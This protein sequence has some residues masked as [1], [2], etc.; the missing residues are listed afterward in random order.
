MRKVLPVTFCFLVLSV[1]SSG[2]TAQVTLTKFP[3][4][5]QLY[6]RDLNTNKAVVDITG[7]V[8]AS[9][10][11][12]QI[13]LKKYRDGNLQSTTNYTLFYLGPT[14]TFSFSPEITA[15]LHTYKFV[16]YGYK[17][18]KETQIATVNNVVAGD[19]YIIQGQSNAT[20]N[21]RGTYS[22]ANNADDP[23]NAPNRNWVRVYGNGSATS[24]YTHGWF[25]GKGNSYYD[26]DGQCGQWGMR[27]ASNLAGSKNIPIA[28]FNGSAPGQ[29]MWFFQRNDGNHTDA[30]T[31]YGRLLARI[32]EAGLANSIRGIIWFQGESDIV[33]SLSSSALT[34]DQ[35][36]TAFNNLK[37]DWKEDYPGLTNYY[38]FQ[39]RFGCG[40]STADNCLK[41]QEAQRQLDLDAADVQTLSVSNTNQLFDGGTINYCH[42][43]FYD[44]YKNMGD[45]VSKLMR[46]DLYNENSLPATINSPEPESTTFSGFLPTGEPN[47]ISITLKDQSTTFSQ[48]GDCSGL[49]RLDGGSFTVTSTA[50]SGRNILVSFSRNAGTTTNPTH[51]SYRSHDNVAAPVIVNSA[52]LALIHFDRLALPETATPP[53]PPPACTDI[54]EPNNA[55]TQY[56]GITG[57]KTYTANIGSAT[58]EDWFRFRTW[59]PWHYIRISIW[60]LT[61]NYDIYLYDEFGNQLATSTVYNSTSRVLVYNGGA[62][63]TYYRLKIVSNDGTFDP[64][65]C[66]SLRI[67][68]KSQPISLTSPPYSTSR[69]SSQAASNNL[70]ATTNSVNANSRETIADEQ[71]QLLITKLATYPNPASQ[72][73]FVSYP[74]ARK[75]DLQLKVFDLTG[76]ELLLQK[77]SAVSGNNLFRI[78]VSQ[79]APGSYLLQIRSG[80]GTM[81]TRKFLVGGK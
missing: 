51:V 80:D 3:K 57:D 67:E 37:A 39:I 5:Y 50:I 16:L 10:N 62:D 20:A 29:A 17:N 36:K 15:E 13:R 18:F 27:M 66:Y 63:D 40:M 72:I 77:Q 55:F 30:S 69:V 35:Y 41:I 78:P 64:D 65:H 54:Y 32:Q 14:T 44:G 47:Q 28:L 21:L 81:T 59:A 34:T 56:K 12:T 79:L 75:D 8:S 70:A 61:A 26:Q 76:R 38:I 49:F 24:N 58:D 33:G 7:T 25:I 1:V 52:G 9:T 45:W 2:L 4:D 31:N 43:N 42:Y 53:P 11:Y 48:N 74:A 68:T 23:S 22:T 6:P 19:A 46:R 60:G 71:Q 73:L